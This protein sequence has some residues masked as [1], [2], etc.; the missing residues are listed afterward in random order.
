[1]TTQNIYNF[2]KKT[3]KRKINIGKIGGL[4]VGSNIK[5]VVLHIPSEY[6]YRYVIDNRDKFIDLLKMQFIS[7][8]PGGRL[9]FFQV[10]SNLKEFHTTEK[11]M[12]HK[13]S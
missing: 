4:I 12:N 13:I 3:L 5:E 1:M 8:C 6:D 2:K 11:D 7:R 10:E 9:K